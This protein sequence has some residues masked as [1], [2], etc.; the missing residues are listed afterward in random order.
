MIIIVKQYLNILDLIMKKLKIINFIILAVL[1]TGSTFA[2]KPMRAGTTAANFLEIGFGSAGNAMG[3]A[4]ASIAN[5]VS[6]IYWNPAGL[7]GIEYNEAMFTAQPWVADI[8]TSF[9]AVAIK[10]D[11][12]GTIGLGFINTDYGKMDVTTLEMQEGTGETFSSS[13]NAFMISYA[14]KLAEWFSFGATAKYISSNIWHTS[15]NAIAFDLG[16]IINTSF[17]TQTGRAEDGLNIGMSISNYGAPLKY[18]GMDLLNPIDI[19]TNQAGNYKDVQGQFKLQEWEL[20]LIFRVGASYNAIAM[21][22]HTLTLAVNALHPNNNT[23]SVN[24]GAQYAFNLPSFGKL[25]IR[26]GYK[27]LFMEDS[28]YG[29]SYG[30]GIMTNKLFNT[31]IKFEYAFR[32]IGVLGNNHCYGISVMF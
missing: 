18:D 31:G 16:V 24:V 32:D 5:D 19:S 22:N 10:I 11:G 17:F 13:D 2:Q 4:Y 20:P 1:L 26:G 14:R 21:D 15:A 8:S 12:I 25:F 27:A 23:E 7:A 29:A 3:D 9:A 30:F 6:A 28:E